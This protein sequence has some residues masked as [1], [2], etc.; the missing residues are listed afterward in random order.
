MRL[1]QNSIPQGAE[2]VPLVGDVCYILVLLPSTGTV[3]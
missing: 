3:F 2:I 1:L